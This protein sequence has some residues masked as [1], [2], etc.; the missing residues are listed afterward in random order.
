[1][2]DCLGSDF[3]LGM[4]VQGN[5]IMYAELERI[6]FK[7]RPHKQNNTKGGMYRNR[8]NFLLTQ[9]FSG[10]YNS[11]KFLKRC[12]ELLINVCKITTFTLSYI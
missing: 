9:L 6:D 11:L 2:S 8:L 7:E 1:M 3:N 10:K 12:M 4:T 5:N